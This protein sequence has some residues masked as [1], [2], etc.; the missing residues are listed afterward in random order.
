M[1]TLVV[2]ACGGGATGAQL[3]EEPCG[4]PQVL[5]G[6]PAELLEASGMVRDPRRQG[7]F[8]LHNDSG[9]PPV[10]Y[11]VDST[12]RLVGSAG[13]SGTPNVDPEDIALARC[14]EAWCLYLADIGDN[15]A[16]RPFIL[17]HRLPLPELPIE[18]TGREVEPVVP[19]ASYMLVYPDG[20]RDAES[21]IVDAER[22]ELVIVS[23][24]RE[25]MVWLYAARL[26]E[27]EEATGGPA[28]TLR[29]LGRLNVPIGQ[30]TSQYLTAADLSPDGTRLAIRSYSTLFLLPW[31]GSAGFDSTAA[32]LDVGL[33][34]AM[35]PQ[36]E[37]LAFTGDGGWVYLAS[38]GRDGR[39]P[40]LTRIRCPVP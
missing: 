28:V 40:Q 5:A 29:R 11:A 23:K 25:D 15:L 36:G 24:G 3:G 26:A 13:V 8:W 14:G 18:G 32:P 21:L 6:L 16:R 4:R 27:L 7:L 19:L 22:G 39:P 31:S 1:A 9:N 2:T 10:L 37:G 35:E 30:L 20:P 34:S 38:E 17:V 12:G 33:S